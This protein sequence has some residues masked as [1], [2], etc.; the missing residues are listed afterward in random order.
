MNQI[1]I[2]SLTICLHCGCSRDV[3]YYQKIRL[4]PLVLKYKI[5]WNNRIDR[6]PGMYESYSELINHSV[7]TSSTEWIIL[8]NDRT[9]P[10]VNEVEKMIEL[11][12]AGFACVFMYNVGF[13]A[14]SKELIRCIGWWDQRF[15]YGGWEDRDW[16]WRLKKANLALYESQEGTYDMSWKSPLNVPG[17]ILSGQFWEKKYDASNEKVVYQKLSEEN[18]PQWDVTLGG[19]REDVRKSW[20]TWGESKLNLM[21]D[22]KVRPGSGPS[23]SAILNNRIIIESF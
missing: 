7:A 5:H 8:I 3:V 4:N 19:S 10:A 2:N 6:H 20:K 16:V 9:H 11:L 1:K 15:T 17:A 21:Y 12:Q 18:Y 22:P 13:M 14:F 23:A